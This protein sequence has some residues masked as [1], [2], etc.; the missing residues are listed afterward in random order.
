MTDVAVT[1]EAPARPRRRRRLTPYVQLAPGMAWMLAFLV[2][3]VL[4]MVYVS[5]WN[6]TSFGVSE[7][8][9]FDNW[10][11]FFSQE[12]YRNALFTTIRTWLIVL[13]ASIVVGY[14]VAMYVGLFVRNRTLQTVLLVLAIIPFW[15]SFLIRIIAWRPMLGQNGAINSVLGKLGIEPLDFLLYSQVGMIIGMV[16]IYAVFMV[17]PVSFTLARIDPALFEAARD[18]G[19]GPWRMFKD[20]VLPLSRP[21]LVVGAIFVSVL[22]LGEFATPLALS[23]RKVNLLGNIIV[24]QVGG[25]KWAVASVAGVTLTA[26]IAVVIVALLRITDLRKEL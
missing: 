9:T 7:A 19:A 20:I 23:G 8:F 3:P 13:V 4:M 11:T 21:G 18:L 2:V 26:V 25:L 24:N 5:F 6:Q 14:P 17:G 1:A 10:S 15:T 22:V 12:A 16:Q